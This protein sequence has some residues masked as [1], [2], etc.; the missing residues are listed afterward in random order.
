MLTHD[1]N[2]TTIIWNAVTGGEVGHIKGKI[3]GFHSPPD[4][5]KVYQNE[6]ILC[7]E[8]D[9]KGIKI[10]I[11]LLPQLETSSFYVP[12][13]NTARA[14]IGGKDRYIIARG[15]VFV[16]RDIQ[17]GTE[18]KK[19]FPVNSVIEDIAFAGVNAALLLSFEELQKAVEN[20]LQ[21]YE[22]IHQHQIWL[23]VQKDLSELETKQ[24][25]GI[26]Y[27][28]KGESNEKK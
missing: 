8:V 11:V 24:C 2:S 6:R 9:E 3:N 14:F 22:I 16:F 12:I 20:Y 1:I 4:H 27:N 21:L 28:K 13:E 26:P 10:E 23:I 15:N 5:G 7:S 19:V 25:A 18:F 17:S